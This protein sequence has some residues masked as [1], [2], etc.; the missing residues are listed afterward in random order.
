MRRREAPTLYQGD[1]HQ[2]QGQRFR[3]LG[4]SHAVCFQGCAREAVVATGVDLQIDLQEAI[5]IQVCQRMRVQDDFV[6]DRVV[7]VADVVV[8][9]LGVDLGLCVGAQDEG[10]G[11]IALERIAQAQE[12]RAGQQLIESRR[13]IVASASIVKL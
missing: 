13:E 9:S 5:F 2:C 1:A 4:A 10:V 11:F 3:Y 8:A 12:Q 6:V 7:A